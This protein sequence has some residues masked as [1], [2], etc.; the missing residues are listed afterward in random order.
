MATPTLA[1][2]I[3]MTGMSE[4]ELEYATPGQ[5]QSAIQKSKEQIKAT[6]FFINNEAL[7]KFADPAYQPKTIMEQFAD[8]KN[9]PMSPFE[10]AAK[11]RTTSDKLRLGRLELANIASDKKLN[12]GVDLLKKIALNK[13]E[14]AKKEN[15]KRKAAKKF[16]PKD[17]VLGRIF[18][19]RVKPGE[20]ISNRDKAMAY[21]RNISD[22]LLERRLV[23][24]KEGTDTLSRILG[25][26]GGIDEGRAEVEALEDEAIAL[27]EKGEA[28]NLE[29]ILT[30]QKYRKG[31]ADIQKVI[32]D[33]ALKNAGINT[34]NMDSDTKFAY[35][36]TLAELG[37]ENIGT[38]TFQKKLLENMKKQQSVEILDNIG[39]E[40]TKALD[41]LRTETPGTP[42]YDRALEMM[43]LYGQ[44]LP[45]LNEV[46]ENK[47]VQSAKEL[48]KG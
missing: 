19:K 35:Y 41:S 6:P 45:G 37:T 36:Q 17:T 2:M 33:T 47:I 4:E 29:N 23:G 20:E 43:Q 12:Q 7:S 44:Y 42:A 48:T 1:E 8:P 3:Q 32:A 18:D 21:I 16:I 5:I 11:D 13:K 27:R 31:E 40:Y 10:K 24:G 15:L 30:D 39:P 22:N 9:V 28:K 46:A 14:E 34:E 26:G 25:P 38:A